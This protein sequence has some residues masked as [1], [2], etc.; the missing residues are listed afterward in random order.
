MPRKPIPGY[1]V[2]RIC[3]RLANAPGKVSAA[4]IQREL[5]EEAK[6]LRD[7][8]DRNIRALA[9][10]VPSPRSIGRIRENRWET[11]SESERTLFHWPTSMEQGA[12]PWEVAPYALE[13]LRFCIDVV[14]TVG[15]YPYPELFENYRRIFFFVRNFP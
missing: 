5:I 4:Q 11:L 10:K 1:W 3:E 14:K 15:W 8:P 2:D 9:D 6:E 13:C 7:S 12:L